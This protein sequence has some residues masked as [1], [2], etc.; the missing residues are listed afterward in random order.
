MSRLTPAIVSVSVN[1]WPIMVANDAKYTETLG[2]PFI[3]FYDILMLKKHYEKCNLHQVTS[4]KCEMGGFPYPRKCSRC[5]CPSGYGGR[6]CN[7]KPSGGGSVL[8]AKSEYKTP[9]DK[10]GDFRVGLRPREDMTTC[11]Y[12]IK[13]PVG[14][15]IEVKIADL[16]RSLA[17]DGCTYWGVE[18]KT[19]TDQRLTGYRFCSPEDI[20]VTLVSNYHIVPIITYY[21]SNSVQ[22]TVSY[23]L[24]IVASDNPGA[25]S[26]PQ[27]QVSTS[28]LYCRDN[29]K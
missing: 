23:R 24:Y 26:K 19:H 18:I 20:G 10:V 28:D 5:I 9:S 29:P 7:E 15:R 25:I 6:L 1:G 8:E 21:L 4:A 13:A 14:L 3:S 12:W 2:S 17:V 16:S 22:I 27:P 11:N